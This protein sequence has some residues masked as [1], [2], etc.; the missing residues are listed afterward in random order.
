MCARWWGCT[1]AAD[2]FE[3]YILFRQC[4]D[5]VVQEFLSF[6]PLAVAI[7]SSRSVYFE[8]SLPAWP[9]MLGQLLLGLSL[10]M[11]G[12]LVFMRLKKG[13]ADAF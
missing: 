6:N 11:V 1:A 4:N 7:E 12:L 3:S 9:P 5:R 8:N 2:V 10:V 13:F